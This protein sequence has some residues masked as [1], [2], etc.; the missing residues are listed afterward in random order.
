MRVWLL[1]I[2]EPLPCVGN[3]SRLW[4]TG[5][6]AKALAHKGHQVCWWTS[7][8]C[9]KEKR[10]LA[11]EDTT[12]DFL[13]RC[14]IRMLHATGYRKNISL[15][16]LINHRQLADKFLTEADR[17]PSPD[18]IVSSLPTLEFCEA[19]TRLGYRRNIPVVLDIRDLWP[20]I[21]V[22]LTPRRLHGLTRWFLSPIFRAARIACTRATA[23]TG[24]TE[25]F[26][27]WSLEKAGRRRRTWDRAFPMGYAKTELNTAEIENARSFWRS[28]GVARENNQFIVCFFGT[29]GRHFETTTVVEAARQLAR[30]D[31]SIRFVICGN[32]E[33]LKQWQQ[34]TRDLSNVTLPGW[35]NAAQIWTLMRMSSAALAP[36]ISSHDFSR[37]LPNKSI[38]YLSSGLPVVSSLR[39]VLEDLLRQ[40]DCGITYGNG[41]SEQLAAA[42]LQLQSDPQLC[43]RMAANSA[44]VYRK[45]F[46]AEKTYDEMADHITRVASEGRI[47]RAA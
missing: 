11:T 27:E 6:L 37:S 40:H 36:Y 23:L 21:F 42:L 22:D 17:S 13:P 38:E 5:H 9:H 25:Q 19:A 12:V 33:S 45:H 41:Q 29:L 39:G 18:I 1:S 20:D 15:K 43:R 28:F 34:L 30:S 7:T 4:R 3:G 16:R 24:I 8:F 46:I 32:G 14:E 44:A 2:G 31:P 35:V 26:V 47:T 10:H